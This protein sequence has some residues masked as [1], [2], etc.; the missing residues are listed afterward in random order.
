MEIHE[1]GVQ[2]TIPN[3]SFIILLFTI[4]VTNIIF[5]TL[6]I[7]RRWHYLEPIKVILRSQLIMRLIIP[8]KFRVHIQHGSNRQQI[9][10]ADMDF[11][12]ILGKRKEPVSRFFSKNRIIN[13]FYT[14]TFTDFLVSVSPYS[15][16]PFTSELSMDSLVIPSNTPAGISLPNSHFGSVFLHAS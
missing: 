9:Q 12:L 7:N 4:S 3:P 16:L 8:L 6:F 10:L 11:F 5:L 1:T 2:I 15:P 13:S 14:E